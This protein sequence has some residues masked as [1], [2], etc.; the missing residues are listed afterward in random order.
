MLS[1]GYPLRTVDPLIDA[2]AS[3]KPKTPIQKG[4]TI[5]AKVKALTEWAQSEMAKTQQDQEQQANR[6]RNVAPAYQVGDK[7]YLSLR[8]VRTQR[9]S[10]K[11]E[12]RSAKFTVL[13]VISPASYKLDT[14]PGIH[15]VFHVDLLRPAAADPF[16]S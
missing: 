10:K 16:P 7:V 14:P 5:V 12:A 9:P 13:E 8:N 11:L 3:V 1:H 4:E 6:S 2:V 15:N